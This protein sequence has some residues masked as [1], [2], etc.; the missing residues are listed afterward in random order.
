MNKRSQTWINGHKH[1]LTVTNMDK[2]S[3]TWINSHKHE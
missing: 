1:G 3:Q 2:R